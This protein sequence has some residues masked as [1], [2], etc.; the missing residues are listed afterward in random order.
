MKKYDTQTKRRMAYFISP[1]GFGHAARAAA[2][3]AALREFDPTIWFEIFTQV[4]PW[5]FASSL[6][7]AFNHHALLTDIGLVQKNS[8]AEDL[9]ETLR[10]LKDFL[11]FDSTQIKNLAKWVNRLGCQLI[12]CDIAPMGL[13][14]AKEAGLT[15]VLVENFTWDWIYQGYEPYDE[16]ISQYIAYLQK[17][18]QTADYHIQTEP[19]CDH[20][21]VDLTTTPVSRKVRAP[22]TRIR[23]KL[24]IPDQ[25]KLVLITM[26]GN[27]WHY[28]FLKQ[29]ESEQ[30]CYFIVPGTSKQIEFRGNLVLLPHHSEFFHP[31]LVN[32][33]D[34]VIGKIGYS[35]V[36][37][38]YHAGVPFGYIARSKFRE[39]QALVAFIEKQMD[40]I[41][42][43]ETQFQNGEWLSLLPDLL[44]RPRIRRRDSNGAEQVAGF[45]EKILQMAPL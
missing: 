1:H 27:S 7:D 24:G 19:V 2:V 14:V 41:Q 33:C 11:P 17:L 4:P 13:A 35:T 18:F 3:M 39:S 29:L 45:I 31:D 10:R 30:T 26:G 38:A 25:A 6:G 9:P 5:F 23:R 32:A 20:R 21:V 16:R 34:T 8:L 12:I 42:I 40:G 44:A 43:T 36:A 28:T 15:G 37:E 22:A